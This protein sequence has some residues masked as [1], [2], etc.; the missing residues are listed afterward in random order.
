MNLKNGIRSNADRDNRLLHT[1]M[2]VFSPS[3]LNFQEELH[4]QIAG[5]RCYFEGRW[6]LFEKQRRCLCCLVI[7]R[8]RS[9]YFV[10]KVKTLM[11]IPFG[12]HY[13]P[14]NIF[15]HTSYYALITMSWFHFHFVRKTY[16]LKSI[17]RLKM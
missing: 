7:P 9:M 4:S 11:Y 14:K 10:L 16:V 1:L 17:S 6:M 15:R 5:V 8:G 2:T 13:K 12:Q 3:L